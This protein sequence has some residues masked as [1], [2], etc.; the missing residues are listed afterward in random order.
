MT[1]DQHRRIRLSVYP[2]AVKRSTCAN[3]GTPLYTR[4]FQHCTPCT[5][6]LQAFHHTQAARYARRMTLHRT[7]AGQ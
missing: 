2:P 6:W 5:H 4:E 7:G 3:C 1:P